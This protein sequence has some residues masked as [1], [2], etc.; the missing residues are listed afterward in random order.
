[1]TFQTGN[2]EAKKKKRIWEDAIKRALD[3]RETGKVD[4]KGIDELADKL[5]DK[6]AQGDM[7]A[8]KE[9]GDRVDGKPPQA[10]TGEDGGA[11][12]VNIGSGAASAVRDIIS[13]VTAGR[14]NSGG[15]A[16]KMDS[17][18]KT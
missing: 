2:Q 9:I 16:T 1:M 15:S 7:V 13:A 11:I 5:I 10:I 17:G 14:S 8:L 6:A 12:D 18:S 3:R 4:Y